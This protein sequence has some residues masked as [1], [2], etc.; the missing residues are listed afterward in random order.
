MKQIRQILSKETWGE[1]GCTIPVLERLRNHALCLMSWGTPQVF[2]PSRTLK[3][4]GFCTV[5]LINTS[6]SRA[7][8]TSLSA[9]LWV[10]HW[11]CSPRTKTTF[12]GHL[13][14]RRILGASAGG[15]AV[16]RQRRRTQFRAA[17]DRRARTPRCVGGADGG[18][19]RRKITL[20]SS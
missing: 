12:G 13:G 14:N 17:A 7:R 2:L 19:R 3:G 16:T 10:C 9:E 4:R 5:V 18:G 1:G 15:L 20:G 8:H 11:H 6:H